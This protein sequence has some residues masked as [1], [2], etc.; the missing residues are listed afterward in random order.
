MPCDSAFADASSALLSWPTTLYADYWLPR[1]ELDR[2]VASV[3]KEQSSTTLLL[4][5][6]GSGK[7]ALL[8]KLGQT[9]V[10]AGTI[11]LALKADQLSANIDSLGSTL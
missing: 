4:G 11:V 10:A 5:P 9:S 2:L 7:S 3:G 6:P 8:A 1:A